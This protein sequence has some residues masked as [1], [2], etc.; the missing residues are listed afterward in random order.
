MSEENRK[1]R[2][3]R[4]FARLV[5]I[6]APKFWGAADGKTIYKKT[7]RTGSRRW[8]KTRPEEVI[9]GNAGSILGISKGTLPGPPV[10]LCAHIMAYRGACPSQKSR[11][12]WKM[13]PS[14]PQ[15]IPCLV[16]TTPAGLVQL[17]WKGNPHGSG[18]RM[19]TPGSGN[20]PFR[21]QQKCYTKGK[22][23]PLI[24]QNFGETRP[25][26]WI[27]PVRWAWRQEKP[28]L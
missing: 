15:E 1:K 28:L 6:D 3:C 7:G 8:K 14:H 19:P 4:E 11:F 10:L 23:V 24:L 25:M 5:E 13:E 18:S 26:S 9:G 2:I 22:A 17:S 12:F 27:F 16:Q 21:Q 20:Y